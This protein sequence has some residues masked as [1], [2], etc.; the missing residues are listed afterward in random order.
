M[1][2]CKEKTEQILKQQL[3]DAFSIFQNNPSQENSA[4]LDMVK[5]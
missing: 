4:A 2:K 1:S 3:Q 5:I